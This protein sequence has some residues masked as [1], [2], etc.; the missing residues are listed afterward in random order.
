MNHWISDQAPRVRRTIEKVV[1]KI[2]NTIQDAVDVWK[3]IRDVL[4][5]ALMPHPEARVAVM[6]AIEQEFILRDAG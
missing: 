1:E 4:D 2:K 6:Q 3:R 5:I